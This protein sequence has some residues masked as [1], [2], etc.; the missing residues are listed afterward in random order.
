MA[1][2][3]TS[4]PTNLAQGLR[5]GI[6]GGSL[7]GCATAIEL[8]RAGCDVTVFERSDK[9]LKSRGA[10]ISC[11]PAHLEVMKERNLVDA[12]LPMVSAQHAQ[13]TIRADDGAPAGR[14]LWS[15][16][17]NLNSMN[18]GILF[19]NHR[20]RVSDD[21]Y[22]A[23]RRV[24]GMQDHEHGPV[25]LEFDDGE[26]LEFDLVVFADGVNSWGRAQL[27]PE[28]RMRYAGYVLW[29]G[30]VEEERVPAEV[31]D[32]PPTLEWAVH[33][34]GVCV[35]YKIPAPGR[36]S[37]PRG[38]LVNWIWYRMLPEENLPALF[39]DRHGRLHQ[40]SI[41]RGAVREDEVRRMTE[42]AHRLLRGSVAGVLAATSEPF[43]H[44]AYDLLNVPSFVRGHACLLGDAAS[45][46]RAH[47]AAAAVKAQNEAIALANALR[48]GTTV[49]EALQEWN[50][51]VYPA[52]E[53]MVDLGKLLGQAQLLDPPDWRTMDESGMASWWKDLTSR[54]QVY[55][56]KDGAAAGRLSPS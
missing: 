44:G 21:V 17:T 7:S 9:P 31:R 56:L 28:A 34:E 14:T 11:P 12:D 27:F 47:V 29:R 22:Q 55:Y 52:A 46:P 38:R 2:D 49:R 24:V 18:W 39:T 26:R 53:R 45:I 3:A 35:M 25:V 41:P 42:D 5:V 1:T 36:C 6:V 54:G 23:G 51:E 8:K 16:T 43:V 40:G 19:D 10:G 50:T 30:T 4:A 48:T 32:A 13:W 33:E 37:G 15:T 20:S